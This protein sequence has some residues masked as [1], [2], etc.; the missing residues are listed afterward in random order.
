MST[1][2]LHLDNY[3]FTFGCHSPTMRAVKIGGFNVITSHTNKKDV[4]NDAN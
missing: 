2:S 3:W 4:R 1:K